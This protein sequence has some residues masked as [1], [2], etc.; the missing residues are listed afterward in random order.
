MS[1]RGPSFV[2]LRG[3]LTRQT[4]VTWRR[5]EIL[6][7]GLEPVCIHASL[8]PGRLGV[9]ARPVGGHVIACADARGRNSPRGYARQARRCRRA[10]DPLPPDPGKNDSHGSRDHAA[11]RFHNFQDFGLVVELPGTEYRG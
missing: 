3:R 4:R 8:E 5:R 9:H 6:R 10:I 7:D 2:W 11:L 1:F